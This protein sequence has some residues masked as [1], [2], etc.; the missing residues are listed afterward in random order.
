MSKP[1][2]GIDVDKAR[3]SF[4]ALKDDYIYADNAGGSQ[5]LKDVVDRVT[6]YLLNTNVQLDTFL[7]IHCLNELQPETPLFPSLPLPFIH[8]FMMHSH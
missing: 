4:H 7:Y 2:D 5:C 1:T 8:A 3:A 6:D